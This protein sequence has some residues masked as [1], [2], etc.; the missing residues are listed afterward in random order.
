M[1]RRTHSKK[2]L[3]LSQARAA[4]SPLV[5]EVAESPGKTVPISVRG[6]VKAYVIGAESLALL[7]VREAQRGRAR[8]RPPSFEGTLE[9]VSDLE[10]GSREAALELELAALRSWDK[11]TKS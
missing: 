10:Q 8:P 11:A 9:I 3:T 4:L 6:E 1:K 2:V 5:R 7:E